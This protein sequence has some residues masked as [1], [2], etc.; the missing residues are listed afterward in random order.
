MW[1]VIV[2]GGGNAA[3]CAALTACVMAFVQD[4]DRVRRNCAQE[5]LT[6]GLLAFDGLKSDFHIGGF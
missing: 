6:L 2:V 4:Q 3:L 1:D 5:R